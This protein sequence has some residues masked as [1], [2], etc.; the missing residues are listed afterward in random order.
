MP[1][2]STAKSTPHER[3]LLINIIDSSICSQYAA[4][5]LRAAIIFFVIALHCPR[6]SAESCLANTVDLRQANLP[7]SVKNDIVTVVANAV[8]K[9]F[10][11]FLTDSPTPQ[12]IALSSCTSFPKFAQTGRV[13][14]LTQGH[15]YPKAAGS[16]CEDFW[17]FRQV[18]GQ[19]HLIL[20]SGCLQ[21]P[22][23]RSYHHGM[24]DVQISAQD[25]AHSDS[26]YVVVFRFNGRRYL[27]LYCY[28]TDIGKNGDELD[29]PKQPCPR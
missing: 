22:A 12:D 27:P 3:A 9:E 10:G 1:A 7:A 14:L 25:T 8:I 6:T 21:G 29:G 2:S 4:S 13:I 20:T 15:D 5:V 26:G 18:G 19:A 17:L 16:P 24:L 11:K 23:S 28:D